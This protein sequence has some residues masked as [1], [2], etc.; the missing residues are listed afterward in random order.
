[1]D[2][3]GR[4]AKGLK[5]S[6]LCSDIQGS[7]RVQG[8]GLGEPILNLHPWASLKHGQENRLWSKA[9]FGVIQEL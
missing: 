9:W 2:R 8:V 1:M 6:P 5:T 7:S 3:E 4:R